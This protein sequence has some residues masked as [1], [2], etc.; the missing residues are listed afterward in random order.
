MRFTNFNGQ[1]KYL[2]THYTAI[3]DYK[4]VAEEPFN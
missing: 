3:Y 1:E 2:C 4:N